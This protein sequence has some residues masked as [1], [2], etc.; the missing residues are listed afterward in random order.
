MLYR[1]QTNCHIALL[2]K[3]FDIYS[4]PVG[5]DH[6]KSAFSVA[7]LFSTSA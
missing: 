5:T 6:I 2:Y 3:W 1:C 4:F 7:S